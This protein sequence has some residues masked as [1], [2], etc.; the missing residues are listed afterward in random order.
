MLNQDVLAS[1]RGAVIGLSGTSRCDGIDVFSL[2][3]ARV[4][5]NTTSTVGIGHAVARCTKVENLQD[6]VSTVVIWL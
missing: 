2:V 5:D 6:L 1:V 4:N 3:A